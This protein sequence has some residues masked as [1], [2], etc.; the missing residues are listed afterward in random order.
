M[1]KISGILKSVVGT[2]RGRIGLF[3]IAAAALGAFLLT[4]SSPSVEIVQPTKGPAVQA[5]YGTGAIEPV[6]WAKVASTVAGRIV[7]IKARD[8]DKVKRG[9]VLLQLDDR[10]ARAKLAEFEANEKFMRE[11]LDRTNKLIE[12]N[13]A[14][15]QQFERAQSQMLAAR[16][17]VDAQKQKVADLRILSPIDGSVLRQDGNIGEVVT[18]GQALFWIGNCCPMRVDAEIDE[19]QIPLVKVGQRALV[20]VDAFPDRAFAGQVTEITQKGDPVNKNYRVRIALPDD[21]PL[22]IGMTTEINVVVREVKDAMLVPDR[23]IKGRD[24]VW[25]VADGR[26]QL[27]RVKV[28]VRGQTLSEITEGLAAGDW[29]IA[30]PPRDLAAGTRVKAKPAKPA[31]QAK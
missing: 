7:D 31:A 3:A 16:A 23:A 27:K 22:M 24:Q 11:E 29:V 26:A 9:D 21:T 4:G 5:V 10:E 15:R 25:V 28:G 18:V 1:S 6:V 14:S 19:E 2:R 20:K 17:A 8:N 30:N 13:V 12:R